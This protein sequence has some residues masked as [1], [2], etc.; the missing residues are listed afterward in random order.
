MSAS[1]AEH[2]GPKRP[3]RQKGLERQ[4]GKGLPNGRALPGKGRRGAVRAAA[5]GP[6]M[7]GGGVLKDG[8]TNSDQQTGISEK[9]AIYLL[10]V[11][12]L[13]SAAAF[14]A[15]SAGLTN[16]LIKARTTPLPHSAAAS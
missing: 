2:M 10:I 16:R 12:C 4:E 8:G 14:L 15:W 9:P 1:D 11:A 13:G 7:E 5:K 6:K 3:K